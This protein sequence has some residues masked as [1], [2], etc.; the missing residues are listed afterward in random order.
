MDTD[1]CQKMYTMFT[2]RGTP[3]E[4]KHESVDGVLYEQLVVTV[5]FDAED[6]DRFGIHGYTD[7]V[8]E[9]RFVGGRFDSIGVWE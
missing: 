6:R 4:H 5:P 8:A 9:F 1:D 3:F 2:K 7:F